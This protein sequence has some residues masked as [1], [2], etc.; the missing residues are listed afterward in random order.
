MKK[1]RVT[2]SLDEDVVEGL[3]ALR[4]RSMSAAANDTLRQ[5]LRTEAHRRALLRWLDELDARHGTATPPEAALVEELLD[6]L[7]GVPAAQHGAA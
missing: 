1:R 2:L 6:E 5:A 4:A 7:Q 3:E